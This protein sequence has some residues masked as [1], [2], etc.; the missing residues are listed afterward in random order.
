MSQEALETDRDG[1]FNMEKL[2][3]IEFLR[4]MLFQPGS[5]LAFVKKKALSQKGG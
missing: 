1:N 5:M 3:N 2:A 4:R